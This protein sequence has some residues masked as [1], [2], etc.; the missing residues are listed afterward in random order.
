VR[1]GPIV[2]P[3]IRIALAVML[4]AMAINATVLRLE[5]YSD[6]YD[7]YDFVF[8]FGWG[9]EYRTGQQVWT[10]SSTGEVEPGVQRH[11][12]NYTPPFVEAFAPLTRLDPPVA[13][14]IWQ[15][16]QIAFLAL[17]LLLLT[18]EVKP[19]LDPATVAIFISVSLMFKPVLMMIISGE[20]AGLLLLLLTV[21]WIF[22]RHGRPAMAGLS[23]AAGV[24]LKL[25]PGAL[26]FY[27]LIRK[28]WA[29][30]WWT[31]LFFFAGVFA[32]GIDNWRKFLLSGIGHTLKPITHEYAIHASL[33]PSVYTMLSALAN[34]GTPSWTAVI[35][36]TS[37]LDLMVIAALVWATLRAESDSVSDGIVFGLWLTAMLLLSPLAWSHELVLLFPTF[38]FAGLAATRIVAEG[39]P[40]ARWQLTVGASLL[41]A[42][43]SVELIHVL[44]DFRQQTIPHSWSLS[45]PCSFCGA[46]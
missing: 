9:L 42:C 24:L 12:C 23:L 26:A 15:I 34:R 18:I 30:L 43:A 21:S 4:A 19:R 38:L 6:R 33:L 16:L 40:F 11:F 17:A 14:W 28:R 7:S 37:I 3:R 39:R 45:A 31:S 29:E 32:S 5:H 2:T 13:H 25:Y 1:E 41:G 35:A 22:A 10:Q 44:P 27:F 20:F 8:F 36:I 46:G